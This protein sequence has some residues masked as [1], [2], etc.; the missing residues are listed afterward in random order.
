M[1]G[2]GR[3]KAFGDDSSLTGTY[4]GEDGTLSARRRR[5][6]ARLVFPASWAVL[7]VAATGALLGV[8][9]SVTYQLPVLVASI[10]IL[11]LPHGAVDHLL[12][13]RAR[14]RSLGARWALVVGGTYLVTGGAYLLV[15]V[16]APAV[17]FWSFILLTWFHWGQGELYPLT[18]LA[19][20]EHVDGPRR[21][22]L[23][24]LSRG[25]LPMLVPLVAFPGQYRV[26][27]DAA[28][29]VV[30][31]SLGPTEMMF[32]PAGRTAVGLVVTA[33]VV[34]NLGVGARSV[35]RCRPADRRGWLLDAGE[36]VGLVAYFLVVPPVLAIGLYFTLWH[37]LRHAVRY[38]SL[39]DV[40]TDEGIRAEIRLFARDSAPL[41]LAA[42]GILIALAAIVPGSPR[43]G[44]GVDPLGFVGVYLLLLAV[45]T[46]PHVVFV[47]SLD[48]RQGLRI[49]R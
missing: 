34:V 5:R 45:L 28:V 37:S 47:S 15:W 44:V 7:G 16:V 39:A 14:G 9:P 48:R 25:S 46:L 3:E 35:R 19:G 21:R 36:T 41:T 17:G 2:T 43:T 22:L 49:G 10:L 24:V 40:P 12:R 33:L 32:E 1:S 6:F 23:A 38:V 27:A 29:G 20:V 18:R 31:G 26:V 4:L 8:V 30:G 13:P 42:I 11:G